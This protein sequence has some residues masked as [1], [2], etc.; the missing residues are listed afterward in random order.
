MAF[1]RTPRPIA[2]PL[3]RSARLVTTCLLPDGRATQPLALAAR[4]GTR[5]RRR[6]RQRKPLRG[7][8]GGRAA[9]HAPR[10]SPHGSEPTWRPGHARCCAGWRAPGPTGSTDCR[11]QVFGH[12]SC[13]TIDRPA[14]A[15]QGPDAYHDQ[16]SDDAEAKSAD[17]IARVE[18]RYLR[19]FLRRQQLLLAA[20]RIESDIWFALRFVTQ[21]PRTSH[22][23]FLAFAGREGL[24]SRPAERSRSPQVA[25]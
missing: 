16:A 6:L 19:G 17:I 2:V 18:P 14:A 10:E 15:A 8:A 24:V 5:L 23:S 3:Q 13:L 1:A 22:K 21:R 20:P 9:W 25:P 7:V 12:D 4:F 11:L